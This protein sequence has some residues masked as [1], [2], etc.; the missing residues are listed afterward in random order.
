M[1]LRDQT[2]SEAEA[3]AT[4]R[5]RLAERFGD[6]ARAAPF[7]EGWELKRAAGGGVAL[8]G[9]VWDHPVHGHAFITTSPVVE[10][11]P[12]HARTASGR[13]YVLGRED[14]DHRRR[15]ALTG[16]RGPVR[17]EMPVEAAALPEFRR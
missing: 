17:I 12:D 9:K 15:R 13:L 3:T 5:A 7:I 16:N 14:R 2:P 1:R 6:E 10:L 8:F 4:L 11:G